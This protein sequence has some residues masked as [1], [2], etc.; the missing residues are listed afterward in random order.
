MQGGESISQ[1]KSMKFTIKISDSKEEINKLVKVKSSAIDVYGITI[2]KNRDLFWCV[3]FN[4]GSMYSYPS[5]NLRFLS[6]SLVQFADLQE[7][8][9]KSD[10]DDDIVDYMFEKQVYEEAVSKLIKHECSI[11]DVFYLTE[12]FGPIQ[13]LDGKM[14]DLEINKMLVYDKEHIAITQG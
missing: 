14:I 7:P 6:V 5:R 10:S 12:N 3:D 4:D 2:N 9:P 11:K 8:V 1:H 13:S